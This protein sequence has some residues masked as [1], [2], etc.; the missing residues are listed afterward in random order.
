MLVVAVVVGLARSAPR[1][2]VSVASRA[3]RGDTRITAVGAISNGRAVRRWEADEFLLE[4]GAHVRRKSRDLK[5]Q[6]EE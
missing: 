6:G 4:L 2:S 3:V 5:G 1:I